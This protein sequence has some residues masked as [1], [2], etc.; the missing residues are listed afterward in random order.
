GIQEP[1][2]GVNGYLGAVEKTL[3][4][5]QQ[6]SQEGGVD[7][8]LFCIRAAR[9]TATIQSDYS[10][11]YQVLCGS[12][13]PIS[14]VITYVERHS[15][16]D[17][18]W[19]RNSKNLE[20]FGIKSAGYACVTGLQG[21]NK[22]K[23]SQVAVQK[24][25]NAYDDEGKHSTPLEAWFIQFMQLFGLFAPLKDLKGKKLMDTLTKRCRMDPKVAEEIAMQL[26]RKPRYIL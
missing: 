21:H 11:F 12:A 20:K 18:W 1:R 3:E 25:L 7:L 22:Y 14:L 8:L 16:I 10:L 4:L 5:V 6:L 15:D 13:A 24:L 17:D 19:S 2:V 26:D 9:I 23:D